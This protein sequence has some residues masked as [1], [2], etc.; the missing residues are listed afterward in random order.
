VGALACGCDTSEVDTD[1]EETDTEETDTEETD[2]EETDTGMS[3]S[4][5]ESP[6]NQVPNDP[7]A[8]H[9]WVL[10]RGY[11]EWTSWSEVRPNGGIGGNRVFLNEVLVESLAG[12]QTQH[13]L[14]ATAVREQYGE[15]L[16]TLVGWAVTTR[17]SEDDTGADAWLWFEVFSTEPDATPAV[18]KPGAP[19]CVGCH[20]SA[21]DFIHST[22]PLP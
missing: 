10:E 12:G 8:L 6:E 22:L 19:G 14:G 18:A 16:E 5:T 2:T 17:I 7:V 15:D 11:S 9:E 20:S 4:D 13:P 21:T 3:G 1:F